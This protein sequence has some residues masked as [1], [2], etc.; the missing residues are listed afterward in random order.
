MTRINDQFCFYQL[1]LRSAKKSILMPSRCTAAG[2]QRFARQRLRI[3]I[4]LSSIAQKIKLQEHQ[5]S[6]M[7]RF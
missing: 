3:C 6:P 2:L 4:A 7:T 5:Y 1:V